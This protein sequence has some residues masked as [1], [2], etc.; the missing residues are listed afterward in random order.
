MNPLKEYLGDG[1][2]AEIPCHGTILLTTENG[3]SMT[4]EIAL[5]PEVLR[6]LTDFIQRYKEIGSL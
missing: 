3:I 5:E 1:V 2:Y 6:A 4:N